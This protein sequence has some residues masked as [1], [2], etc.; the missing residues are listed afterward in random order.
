MTD[1]YPTGKAQQKVA[2]ALGIKVENYTDANEKFAA[3]GLEVSHK[4]VGR[5]SVP[6]VRNIGL[7]GG[8]T[9]WGEGDDIVIKGAKKSTLDLTNISQWMED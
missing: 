5:K 1:S 7:G 9:M 8:L 2:D 6:V 4:R 3:L